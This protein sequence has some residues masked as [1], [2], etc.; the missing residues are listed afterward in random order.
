MV[1]IALLL[2]F[3]LFA[4]DEL[5]K[6]DRMF[7]NSEYENVIYEVDDYEPSA[8][9]LEYK[10]L[11]QEKLN[12]IDNAIKTYTKI[13]RDYY[14]ASNK[15]LIE[16]KL[17]NTPL[18]ISISDTEAMVLI[19][20]HLSILYVKKYEKT[21][22]LI[23]SHI[24][25]KAKRKALFVISLLEKLDEEGEASEVL[26]V[27][28]EEHQKYIDSYTYHQSYYAFLSLISWQ[29]KMDLVKNDNSQTS[30]V[31]STVIGNCPGLGVKWRNTY[32]SWFVEN[33]F[34]LAKANASTIE[35]DLEYNQSSVNV[36]GLF[37]GP[38]VNFE[39]LASDLVVGMSLNYLYAKSAFDDA[40]T[41]S[42][43]DKDFL[44]FGFTL[45]SQWNYQK[46]GFALAIGK[47]FKNESSLFQ[48]TTS[49]EF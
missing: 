40:S 17:K 18:D 46:F 37:G 11:A 5:P 22:H 28:V 1:L 3:N 29:N 4:E 7:K 6:L 39:N 43:E 27:R 10:A 24:V 35:G 23:K 9:T 48:L 33:C 38:G 26:K 41:A 31:L 30:E 20:K 34:V 19:Y 47:I 2:S 21:H 45:R 8:K 15:K 16:A 42:L 36:F 25:D 13:L 32:Y 44:R 12:E 14:L 49:Y